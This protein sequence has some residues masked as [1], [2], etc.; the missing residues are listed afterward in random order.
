MAWW[1]SALSESFQFHSFVGLLH[2]GVDGERGRDGL[3]FNIL[4]FIIINLF[5]VNTA[6]VQGAKPV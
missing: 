2:R 3:S 1:R 5:N 4:I 6:Y